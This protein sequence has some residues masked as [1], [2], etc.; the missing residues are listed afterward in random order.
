LRRAERIG[1]DGLD[2]WTGI[3]VEALA[4]WLRPLVAELVR[5]E[6]A[7]RPRE[8]ASPFLSVAEAADY[9]RCERQRIYD[10]VSDG[11]LARHKDGSRVL[12]ARA[13]LERHLEGRQL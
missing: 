13:D 7:R 8:V 11:R 1:R 6:L 5:E 12:I 10:L 9:L 2:G 4:E 3:P